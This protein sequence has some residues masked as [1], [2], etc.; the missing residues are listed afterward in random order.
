M[1]VKQKGLLLVPMLGIEKAAM[2]EGRTD[3]MT[4]QSWVPRM[5]PAKECRRKQVNLM[6]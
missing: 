3:R 5:E 2:L 1:L 6:T 4:V